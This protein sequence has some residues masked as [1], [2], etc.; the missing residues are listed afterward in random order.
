[1]DVVAQFDP[2]VTQQLSQG[3][4]GTFTVSGTADVK[5]LVFNESN[6]SLLFLFPDGRRAYIPAWMGMPFCITY[7]PGQTIWVQ[8]QVLSASGPPISQVYIQTFTQAEPM[9]TTP[10]S[11]VRQTNIGNIQ[12]SMNSATNIVNDGNAPATQIVEA[13]PSGQTGG[14]ATQVFNN[15][16]IILG[17][18]QV[19]PS[20]ICSQYGIA[21]TADLIDAFAIPGTIYIKASGG[22]I[23]FQS[24]NGVNIARLDR[25]GN[26]TIKGALTQHGSP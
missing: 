5:F 20:I 22:L 3:P 8:E 26:L 11:L 2:T 14:S 7:P 1:M 19:A 18:S 12:A 13:T 9:P 25:N 16:K 24:P 17:N 10:F 21:S 6:I 4:G 23:I 15:G